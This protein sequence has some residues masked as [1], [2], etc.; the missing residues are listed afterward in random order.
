MA[1]EQGAWVAQ[2]GRLVY[3]SNCHESTLFTET[4]GLVVV[5]V[6]IEIN[7]DLSVNTTHTELAVLSDSFYYILIQW[8]GFFQA[9]LV[10]INPVLM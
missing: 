2:N 1:K 10:D 8:Y 4:G 6:N 3:L 9:V 7:S 5:C